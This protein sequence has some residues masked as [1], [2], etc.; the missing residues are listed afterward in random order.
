[1]PCIRPCFVFRSRF[2]VVHT[3]AM[4]KN[5]P[6]PLKGAIPGISYKRV[7]YFVGLSFTKE[8]KRRNKHK[9]IGIRRGEKLKSLVERMK[10][11]EDES[12]GG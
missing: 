4:R 11:E 6:N 12:E 5:L 2:K 9:K 7:G 8:K 1:M 10:T 3:L